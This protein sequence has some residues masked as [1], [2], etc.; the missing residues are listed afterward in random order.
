MNI[1]SIPI[2]F[3]TITTPAPGIYFIGFNI[4]DGQ[5]SQMDSNRTITV[6]GNNET[7]RV[8]N[9]SNNGETLL[10]TDRTLFCDSAYSYININL[11]NVTLM[12]GKFLTFINISG[13]YEGQFILNGPFFGGS[14]YNI[15][16]AGNAVTFVS[17]GSTYWIIATN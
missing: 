1:L 2:D 5:L 15:N 8:L 4:V 10:T 3:S 14:T 7:T 13:N 9:N 16:L 6:I 17:D 12:Q 11:P